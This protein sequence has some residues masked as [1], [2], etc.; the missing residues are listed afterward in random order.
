[1][2]NKWII[3]LVSIFWMCFSLNFKS[4]ALQKPDWLVATLVL[5]QNWLRW[6][7]I[8]TNAGGESQRATTLQSPAFRQ[9]P[10]QGDVLVG[11]VFLK[12]LEEQ[13]NSDSWSENCLSH[14]PCHYF[15]LL[16]WLFFR[17]FVLVPCSPEAGRGWSCCLSHTCSSSS[18]TLISTLCRIISSPWW[19]TCS[20]SWCRYL[21]L[22]PLVSLCFLLDYLCFSSSWI[23]I[24]QPPALLPPAVT[25]LWIPP[26]L[27]HQSF[28]Q[29]LSRRHCESPKQHL[30]SRLPEPQTTAFKLM[31]RIP[32]FNRLPV[33]VSAFGSS[34]PLR[35]LTQRTPP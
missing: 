20:L 4:A 26:S 35:T 27:T 32:S 18:N 5:K 17:R 14:F 21:W 13:W 15:W 34:S 7:R 24:L 29:S 30:L 1:M 25:P 22:S 2:L 28:H 10:A 11:N 31:I 23:A 19:G 33:L 3:P 8:S 12:I 16:L 6:Y 9:K